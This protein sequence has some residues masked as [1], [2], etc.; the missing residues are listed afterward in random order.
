MTQSP[1]ETRNI[2]GRNDPCPCESG[3]KYK[4]CCGQDES[5]KHFV[6][7]QNQILQSILREFFENHPR[8]SQ[9]KG[10]LD[11]KNETEDLLVPLYG[12]EKSGSIIGDV[13]FFSEQVA[14]WNDFIQQHMKKEQRP[15]IRKV[16][17]DWLD[18]AF[19]VGEVLSI[20]EYRAQMKDVLTGKQYEID[21]NESFPVESGNFAI[22][23][24]LPD[25]RVASHFLMVLN[26]V[27]ISAE[28]KPETVEKLKQ[29][30]RSS[31]AATAEDFYRQNMI[32]IYQMFSSGLLANQEFDTEVIETVKK[33][34]LFL[35]EEDEKSEVL[36]ET[37]FHYLAKLPQVPPYALAGAVHFGVKQQLLKLS[38]PLEKIA[39]SFDAIQ[40]EIDTFAEELQL[41]YKTA[42]GH[43]E[44]EAAYAFEVGTNPKA[45]EAQNW[46][47]FMHLKNDSIASEA[48][49]KRK[50]EFYR[51]QAYEPKSAAEQA[52]LLAYELYAEN[53]F[54]LPIEK[55]KQ[56]QQLD[57][58]LA[59]GLLLAAEA[60]NDPVA[61]EGLLKEAV[62]N[63]QSAYEPE[64]E[65]AWLYIP[66]RPFLRAVFSLG[67]YYFEQ[68]KLEKAF[69]EFEKLLHLN[70]G[71]HQG[72][73]YLAIASLIG[74]N[75]F[76]QAESLIKHYE[77][78]YSDNAFYA[79]FKWSIQRRKN[80]HAP[81]TQELYMKALDQNPYVKKYID[82][83]P[84]AEAYPKKMAITPRSPEEA[85]LIWTFLAPTL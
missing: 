31:E 69:T 24:F 8:P 21:V 59:D 39:D 70:S 73:R 47:I 55:I 79:W 48:A 40:G 38:W 25:N 12:E 78:D 41:F 67:V 10:L 84:A 83:R 19:I 72:A 43:E 13:Y 51:T 56:I 46:Q 82:K 37:F 20:T 50:M 77:K 14:I 28:V 52:Q 18:P 68:Q 5:G 62:E 57:P 2:I 36:M 7:E 66:N 74:L 53:N 81:S 29:M 44:K 26:S 1:S 65:I 34:E 42:D 85:R 45:T 61:K 22:G 32:A 23:F 9:Q 71:D 11:W 16:L 49:L 80:L 63:G 27:T 64:M 3:K 30:Q 33:L 60:Q 76:E 75:R 58:R 17:T 54:K 6:L 4:K 35:I 15:T